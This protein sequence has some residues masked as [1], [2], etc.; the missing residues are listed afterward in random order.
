VVAAGRLCGR[1]RRQPQGKKLGEHHRISTL[2]GAE[3]RVPE[4]VPQAKGDDEDSVPL[5]EVL[6]ILVKRFPDRFAAGDIA[7][8]IDSDWAEQRSLLGFR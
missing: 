3:D 4:A 5:A 8:I 6:E 2:R 1:I 7:K